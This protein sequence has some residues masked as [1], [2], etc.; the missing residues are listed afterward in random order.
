MVGS[1]KV[2]PGRLSAEA[3][4]KS[5]DAEP[6]IERRRLNLWTSYH[7]QFIGLISFATT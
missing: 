5:I 1:S 4:S 3:L 7:A 2:C 6:E